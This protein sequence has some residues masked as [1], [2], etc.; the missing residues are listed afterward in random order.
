MSSTSM[1][2]SCK[3][4]DDDIN[5]VSDR[6]TVLEAAKVDL[7]NQIAKL[8]AD[9]EANYATKV[10]LANAEDAL[11]KSIL[12]EKARAEAA[13][14]A[15]STRIQTAQDAIDDLNTLIGGDISKSANFADCKTYKEALEKTW[16]KIESVETGLGNRLTAL[17]TDLN[18]DD[19][20]SKIR[21][22]LKN[23]E[24]Q[25]AALEA[26]QAGLDKDGGAATKNY[27]GTEIAAAEGRAALDAAQKAAQALVDAKQYT[28]DEINKAV[29]QVLKD[30][31][32]DAKKKAD[33]AEAAAKSFA[34]DKANEAEANAKKYAAEEAKAKADAAQA[35][36][37]AYAKKYADQ[38]Y[39]EALT[40]AQKMA[41]AA[42]AAAKSYAD[43]LLVQAK[44]YADEV[45]ANTLTAAQTYADQKIAIAKAEAIAKAQELADAAES[46]A[47]TYTNEQIQSLRDNELT[48]LSNRINDLQDQLNVLDMVAKE[49]R[50]LVF[51]PESYY[52][53]IEAMTIHTLNYY[54]Y[55]DGT[56]KTIPAANAD[57]K[58]ARGYS[59]ATAFAG[60][61]TP[62][63][64][65]DHGTARYDS[66]KA[67][68][69]LKFVAQYHMNPSS[70]NL[71]NVKKIAIVD[72][73]RPY[74]SR[75]S[76]AVLSCNSDITKHSWS[77]GILSVNVDVDH[78]DKI[79]SVP[80]DNYVTTFA[81][82]VTLHNGKADTT[83]TSDY[84][85]VYKDTV[86]DL[87]LAHKN[88]M[89][90]SSAY[91]SKKGYVAGYIYNTHCGDC[92]LN[93]ATARKSHLMATVA[94]AAYFAPQ[95]SVLWNE[96]LDL[97][98]LV[99]THFTNLSKNHATM[100]DKEMAA[101]GLS[102]KYELT[103]YFVGGNQ[104]SESAQAALKGS[105]L[106]P[107][108]PNL[109]N[110]TA[111]EYEA[112]K[113]DRSTIGR[114]P[115]VRVSLVDAAGNVL[116]Y[117]YIRIL[118]SETKTTTPP[119]PDQYIEV[120]GGT[121]T[122]GYNGECTDNPATYSVATTWYQTQDKIYST[123]I[124][125]YPMSREEFE[126]NYT[127][128]GDDRSYP[129]KY[130]SQNNLKQYNLK[131]DGTFEAIPADKKVGTVS[132][133]NDLDANNPG[134]VT[135]ILK[136]ELT[137]AQ[138]SGYFLSN[139]GKTNAAAKELGLNGYGKNG[140]AV[141][142]ISKN[143]SSY[144]DFYVLFK[145]PGKANVNNV[146][147][148]A[149]VDYT[150]LKI[151]E[152]WYSHNANN[153]SGTADL[154]EVEIH[155]NVLS[156]EDPQ[157]IANALCE[158]L[159]TTLADVFVGN[160]ITAA[161]FIKNI[162]DATAN[163][164]YDASKLTLSLVFDQKNN[165]SDYIYKGVDGNLY[166]TQ[167]SNNGKTLQAQKKGTNTWVNIAVIKNDGV[168]PSDAKDAINHLMVDYLNVPYSQ[169]LL[170][171]AAHNALANDVLIAYVGIIAQNA[172][173]KDLPLT[174]EPFEVRFLRPIN[175]ISKDAE[176]QDADPNAT[177]TINLRDLINLTDWRDEPFKANQYGIDY[178]TYYN[179]KSIEVN[180]S[181]LYEAIQTNMNITDATKRQRSASASWPSLN[182]ITSNIVLDYNPIT[183]NPGSYGLA[184]SY[185][186]ITY[187]N[188]SNTVGDFELKIPLKITYQ[189]GYVVATEVYV[190]VH[191]TVG[192]A[193]R[194]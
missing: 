42:E 52:F 186:T 181:S 25:I 148:K 183:K 185:G 56:A 70:A 29:V 123:L 12:A 67:S 38:K 68:R 131:D 130:D 62:A 16:A 192:N 126:A 49:L 77:N 53:G 1:F 44:A 179:I 31:A 85:A 116:D 23:L 111:A 69:V 117:G 177:Q 145:A 137:S 129:E 22:Y 161:K 122:Y 175:V 6:V 54:W 193:R 127:Q 40:E 140:I 57:L 103:A 47:K 163:K 48:A 30:A 89:K 43:Q 94:E 51:I 173:P 3:D 153:I 165:V 21:L 191:K 121:Y 150:G 86:Q 15:L 84:A 33:A 20:S 135:S 166:K 168:A 96:T 24:N 143:K 134:T 141:K 75:A 100:T 63:P 139:A 152:Y 156:P 144:P 60:Y 80:A 10:A 182:D 27:V 5:N 28:K 8:R 104:T 39:N 61:D 13:E 102:Y 171:Y 187:Q 151:N 65:T 74:I 170:N 169:V 146:A 125:D 4:Y 188:N 132:C 112:T 26:W 155:A 110:G 58:E 17:E 107:Q 71:S 36:A 78:L 91:A 109:S 180:G 90:W 9:L 113:Q 14:A 97:S 142:Y 136:W 133:A 11:N 159:N 83:I 64:R 114:T 95:D 32:D 174:Q 119:K 76:E 92:A 37:E 158:P 81:T 99:E 167:V 46:A 88:L 87:R 19:P 105:I 7:E 115:V 149:E 34:Q 184:D 82:Q 138:A 147:P 41:N 194:F 18:L 45:G 66:T 59:E 93:T 162:T 73:D 164:E 35:A 189:W 190:K 160:K 172:C 120:V 157:G 101:N 124:K 108:L 50:S 176:V 98:T 118:I 178:W 72:A 128:D 2:V 154:G 106:R 79:K 55:H